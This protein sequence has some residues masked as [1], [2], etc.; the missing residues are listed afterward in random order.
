MIDS[1][2][3][4][5]QIQ[6]VSPYVGY[7]F[8]QEPSG[9]NGTISI[10]TPIYVNPDYYVPICKMRSNL[11]CLQR[12]ETFENADR[13]EFNLAPGNTFIIKTSTSQRF[14]R[15]Q[16]EI[17]L[18]SNAKKIKKKAKPQFLKQESRDQ[19]GIAEDLELPGIYR[20]KSLPVDVEEPSPVKIQPEARN[21]GQENWAQVKSPPPT[22][23][24]FRDLSPSYSKSSSMLQSMIGENAPVYSRPRLTRKMAGR[25][26]PISG[27]CS[28]FKDRVKA[29]YVAGEGPKELNR[30]NVNKSSMLDLLKSNESALEGHEDLVR[31]IERVKS[32]TGLERKFPKFVK[33][34]SLRNQFVSNDAHSKITGPGYSRNNYGKPYFS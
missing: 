28:N 5:K 4:T 18:N 32:L 29:E 20:E 2:N 30:W 19:A 31:N 9:G 34:N 12:P 15:R 10:F 21:S 33:L 26:E 7:N 22:K 11:H 17:Q 3:R 24:R 13:G 25:K 16:S 6:T 8:G 14:G 27:T 23:F 1:F